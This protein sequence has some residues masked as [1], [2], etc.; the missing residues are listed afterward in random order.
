MLS[1]DATGFDATGGVIVA[2]ATGAS[3]AGGPESF[4]YRA[5]DWSVRGSV[6]FEGDQMVLA[7]R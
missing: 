1:A 4:T 7:V 5:D 6:R 3:R 2:T